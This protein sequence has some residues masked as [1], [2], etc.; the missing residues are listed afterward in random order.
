MAQEMNKDGS[1]KGNG[2]NKIIKE[3]EE[4]ENQ[5][6]NNE[7]SLSSV[8]RQ[9]EIKIKLLE[10]ERATKEQEKEK[11]REATEATDKFKKSNSELYDDYLRIKKN[12][13]ELLKSIPPNLKPYYKNKVNEYFKNV[14]GL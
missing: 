9:E 7:L 2:L 6:I 12:E 11:K 1:G 13:I 5:I 8:M 4:I 3:I 10:L 14:E